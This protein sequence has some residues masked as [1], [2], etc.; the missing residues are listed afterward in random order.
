MKR[1]LRG[2]TRAQQ[3]LTHGFSSPLVVLRGVGALVIVNVVLIG[4]LFD[5]DAQTAW[6]G[7][8]GSCT[9]TGVLGS[10]SS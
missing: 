3:R 10:Q 5:L 8:A 7:T 6:R 4:L 9:H 1:E 2:V